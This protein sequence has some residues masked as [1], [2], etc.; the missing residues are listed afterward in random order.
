[1]A[2]LTHL[3]LLLLLGSGSAVLPSIFTSS[4]SAYFSFSFFSYFLLFIF[5]IF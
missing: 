2:P 3:L 4:V 5:P 1:V